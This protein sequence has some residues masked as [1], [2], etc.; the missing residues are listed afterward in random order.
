M[1]ILK[2]MRADEVSGFSTSA[3]DVEVVK[4]GG[5][6]MRERVTVGTVSFLCA[7]LGTSLV[8]GGEAIIHKVAD[9]RRKHCAETTTPAT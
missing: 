8:K 9:N 1:G 6:T 7:F 2:L 4:P 3:H 5:L